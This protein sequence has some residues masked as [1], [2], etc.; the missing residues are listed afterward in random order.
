MGGSVVVAGALARRGDRGGHIWAL[1][2][3][4]LGFRRLGW[5]VLFLDRLDPQPGLRGSGTVE[6]FVHVM[7]G[8]GLDDAYSLDLGPGEEPVGL[9]RARVGERLRDADF[10][11]NIMGYLED[12]DA[13]SRA[14]RRIFLDIDP[15]FGQMWKAL[16]WCDV[17]EGHDAF[18]TVGGNMGRPSCQVPDCGLTWT[19][20]LPPVVL[21]SWPVSH[22]PGDR[23]TSVGAWRGPFD[24]VEF[25]GTT[26]GLRAHEFRRYATLPRD[27]GL[28]FEVALDIGDDD[29]DDARKLRSGGWG[30]AQ[31][32]RAAGS[33]GSYRRYIA[34]SRAEFM[35]AKGMYVR[36][37]SGWF[38][39]RTACYLASGRPAV[40]QDTG[41]DHLLETGEGLLTFASP[42]EALAAVHEVNANWRRHAR[43][44]RALAESHLDSDRV[45]ARVAD[46]VAA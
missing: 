27:S 46:A 40:V 36:S 24:A 20:T 23:F 10:L 7:R 37:A 2:Q 30:L 19:P 42:D 25:E 6:R 39:D 45:L 43:A 16:G 44:A 9:S 17:F 22:S 29:G 4:V 41:L 21:G 8:F 11:L 12:P 35:I 34:N 18:L 14:R 33:P 38:S 28:A 13:L 15:G 3:W 26:Y 31:P 32:H 5:H 1:L